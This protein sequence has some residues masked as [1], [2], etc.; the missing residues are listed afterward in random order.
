[1][2]REDLRGTWAMQREAEWPSTQ[3]DELVRQALAYGLESADSIRDRNISLF[4]RGRH[5]YSGGCRFMGVPFLEDMHML[6]GQDVAIIGVP[7]DCGTTFRSG[8]RWGPQAIRRISLLG[9]GYNPSLGV[10]LV[11]SLNMVDVGDVNVIPANIE[12]SFDQIAKA[13][14]YVHERAV[15]PVI[16]GGD[17]GGGGLTALRC[18]RGNLSARFPADHGRTR[19]TC[20]E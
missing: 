8:T 14:S 17:G 20:F 4:E 19:D 2:R 11:E 16:L 5:G 13:V 10:D 9:T 1:M 7:L 18:S 15:F 6:G 3:R 12:K